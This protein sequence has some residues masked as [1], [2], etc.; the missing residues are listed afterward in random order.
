LLEILQEY[1]LAPAL[2]LSPKKKIPRKIGPT[3]D[4]CV[5]IGAAGVGG[6]G[7]EAL[8]GNTPLVKN[9]DLARRWWHTPLIPA[10]GRQRQVDF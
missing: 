4:E 5:Q 10:L 2:L 7:S 6:A 1:T 8:P 3:E 9:T